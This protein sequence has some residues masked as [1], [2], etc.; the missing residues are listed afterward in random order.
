LVS[1]FT[2]VVVQ[3]AVHVVQQGDVLWRIA[4]EHDTTYQVLAEYNEL[5]NPHLIF[6]GQV[7]RIPNTPKLDERARYTF[8]N[9]FT[10]TIPTF[11]VEQGYE[12]YRLRILTCTGEDDLTLIIDDPNVPVWLFPFNTSLDFLLTNHPNITMRGDGTEVLIIYLVGEHDAPM[13]EMRLRY[14][15]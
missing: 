4:H 10:I 6:P 15:R 8:S 5:D 7:I 1:L 13:W 11:I 12:V 2:P 9:D 3:G 14:L